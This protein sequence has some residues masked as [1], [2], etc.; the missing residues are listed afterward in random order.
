MSPERHLGD[1]R[2]L[3]S[4]A[5]ARGEGLGFK[6]QSLES[7]ACMLKLMLLIGYTG[8]VCA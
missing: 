5:G 6:V 7:R 3:A 4:G 2:V 1:V 8:A